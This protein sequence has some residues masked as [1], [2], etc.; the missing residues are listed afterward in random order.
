MADKIS[1]GTILIEEG[2]LFAR[3]FAVRKR[4]LRLTKEGIVSEKNG[5]K[6]RFG[7][8]RR[9]KILR[10][11]RVRELRKALGLENKATKQALPSPSKWKMASSGARSN[12]FARAAGLN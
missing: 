8:E 2:T 12:G 3:L 10:R 9:R 11:K 4:A 1:M 7:Q 5:D 6:S